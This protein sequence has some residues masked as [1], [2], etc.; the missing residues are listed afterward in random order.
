MTITREP[1]AVQTYYLTDLL[2]A[3]VSVHG[4]K[5]G[6]LSD[7]IIVETE[8]LP[9]VTAL[10]VGRPFG[11]PTLLIPW[12]K[13]RVLASNEIV[14]SVDATQA[15]EGMPQE[16][17]IL[18]RDHVLDKKILDMEDREVEIVYD[19]KLAINGSTLIVTDVNISHYRFLRRLGLKWLAKLIYS[20]RRET[21]D[22]KI[23]WQYVQ[24]LPS[25]IGSFRGDVK[26]K[27]LKESLSEIHPADMADILEE[28]DPRQRVAVFSQLE[29]GKASETLEEID[30]SVQRDMV[31][32]M[33]TEKVAGLLSQ[34]TPGQASDVLAVLP[35][36]AA[37]KILHALKDLNKELSHKAQ[38]ILEREEERIANFST[39]RILRASQDMSVAQAREYFNA[40]AKTVVVIMYLYVV[41]GGG[42]LVGVLDLKELLQADEE[43]TLRDVMIENPITLSPRSTLKDALELFSRYDFRAI[44]VAEEDGTLLGAIPYRDVMN[45]KH[46]FLE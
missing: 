18:L 30:P 16:H 31:S 14:V 29:S 41:D 46:R 38:S 19:V 35:Y 11:Q 28:L 40:Q 8:P 33:H 37:K 24:T 26:L 23:P 22:E 44:P 39:A 45:L 15:Y 12:D 2:G 1:L 42:R 3:R 6:R 25:D 27:V 20:F 36:D 43:K 17:D 34:M 4:R 13:V 21:R 9:T 32:S 10:V 7:M 5:V